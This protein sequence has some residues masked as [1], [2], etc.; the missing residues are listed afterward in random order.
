MTDTIAIFFI[1]DNL[2]LIIANITKPT[3]EGLATDFVD[4]EYGVEVPELTEGDMPELK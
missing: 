2:W 3:K 4:A 1:L